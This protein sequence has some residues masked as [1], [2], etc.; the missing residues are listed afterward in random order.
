MCVGYSVIT[1]KK[2]HGSQRNQSPI[3]TIY[4]VRI[5]YQRISLRSCRLH[6]VNVTFGQGQCLRPTTSKDTTIIVRAHQHR[7]QERHTRHA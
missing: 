6:T 7:S 4:R 5:N 1:D 2:G 3:N